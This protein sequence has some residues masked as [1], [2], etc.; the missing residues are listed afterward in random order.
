[1]GVEHSSA[2]PHL[3]FQPHP[4]RRRVEAALERWWQQRAA[5]RRRIDICA[6][7]GCGGMSGGVERDV[8]DGS[9]TGVEELNKLG[10]RTGQ[11]EIWLKSNKLLVFHWQVISRQ[12]TV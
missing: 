9:P 1:M 4:R 11:P 3:I 12:I 10:N 2:D 6:V 5:R 7:S 8:V